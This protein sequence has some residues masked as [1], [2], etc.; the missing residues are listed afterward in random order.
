MHTNGA[1][2]SSK[3]MQTF[4][5]SEPNAAEGLFTPWTSS[6]V[7]HCWHIIHIS[8]LPLLH[9]VS[10][11]WPRKSLFQDQVPEVRS[12]GDLPPSDSP[13]TF[14]LIMKNSPDSNHAMTLWPLTGWELNDQFD[15]LLCTCSASLQNGPSYGSIACSEHW[16]AYSYEDTAA[17]SM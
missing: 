16:M 3:A 11:H 15:H 13:P 9:R 2:S 5:W 8:E 6:A 17:N 7:P 14:T 1:S 12:T 4:W 10:W